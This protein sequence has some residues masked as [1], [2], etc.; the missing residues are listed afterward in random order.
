MAKKKA[1]KAAGS[2]ASA[3]TRKTQTSKAGGATRRAKSPSAEPE[4]P[5]RSVET[6]SKAGPTTHDLAYGRIIA[7]L[8]QLAGPG[9]LAALLCNVIGLPNE[10]TAVVALVITLAAAVCL[11]HRTID[12]YLRAHWVLTLLLILS[13]VFYFSF[14]T[15]LLKDT[16][17][18]RYYPDANDFLSEDMSVFLGD[19]EQDVL[20]V[21]C[22]FN[23]LAKRKDLLFEQLNAGK[24]LRFLIYDHRGD[25]LDT[26]A[27]AFGQTPD[28]LKAECESG[29]QALQSLQ[30]EWKEARRSNSK[31][32]SLEVRT[33]SGVPHGRY[34]VTDLRSLGGRMYY[35]PYL[36]GVDSPESPGFLLLHT[37][38]GV[39]HQFVGGLSALWDQARTV[40]SG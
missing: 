36:T 13:A 16:G 33:F 10:R 39:A 3:R 31:P 29:F 25:D 35:V 5:D 26:V 2:R 11:C 24:S 32:G 4:A 8:A 20:A 34:Y 1:K 12:K 27:A 18:I 40:N 30:A 7:S 23:T 15:I 17:L 38:G 28:E 14:E 19:A 21:G 22:N 9:A 37:E 6:V